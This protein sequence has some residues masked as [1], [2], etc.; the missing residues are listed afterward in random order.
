MP[1]LR[2]QWRNIPPS[3]WIESNER[4]P[5]LWFSCLSPL[6]GAISKFIFYVETHNLIFFFKSEFRLTPLEWGE[7]ERNLGLFCTCEGVWAPSF[8]WFNSHRL[9]PA[10]SW[11]AAL[12]LVFFLVWKK[13]EKKNGEK[14]AFNSNALGLNPKFAVQTSLTD[15]I[16]QLTP[17]RRHRLPRSF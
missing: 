5:A 8:E 3:S 7:W 17:G 13:F 16:S 14:N 15:G 9:P 11:W 10:A 4:Y 12:H 1:P 6:L 2:Q